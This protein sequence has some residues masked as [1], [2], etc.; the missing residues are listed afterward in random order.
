MKGAAAGRPQRR[1]RL[2]AHRHAG[3]ARAGFDLRGGQQQAL[4]VGVTGGAE[5]QTWA[6]PYGSDLRLM[7]GLGGVPTIHYGPGDVTLAHGPDEHVPLSE[8]R[9]CA[10]ALAALAVQHC[11]IG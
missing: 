10:R 6:A 3:T 11:S 8:V 4:R 5:Q 9:T 2:A 1:R 7:T